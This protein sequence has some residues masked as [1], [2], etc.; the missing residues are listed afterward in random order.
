MAAGDFITK[1]SDLSKITLPS[2]S[3]YDL[4]DYFA[5]H[6]KGKTTTDLTS[7]SGKVNP[8]QLT[9]AENFINGG[10]ATDSYTAHTGDLVVRIVSGSDEGLWGH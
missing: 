3:T 5:A 7:N 6:Y 8:I 10:T 2:G 9:P 1:N 4:K